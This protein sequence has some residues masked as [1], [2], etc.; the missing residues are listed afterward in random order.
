MFKRLAAVLLSVVMVLTMAACNGKSKNA[1]NGKYPDKIELTVWE[2]QGTDYAEREQPDEN[3]VGDWLV[4]K[5]NV[6]VTNKYKRPL[7]YRQRY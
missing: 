1:G 6:E 2:T 7:L 4:E 5:T 3:V